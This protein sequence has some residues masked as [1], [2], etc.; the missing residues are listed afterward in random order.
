M[1]NLEL[2]KVFG[3]LIA[4]A[5]LTKEETQEL[6]D[7]CVASNQTDNHKLVGYINEENNIYVELKNSKVVKSIVLMVEDYIRD[8]DSGIYKQ[9]LEKNEFDSIVNLSDAWYNKQT[10]MEYNPL[11]NHNVA[12]DLV[13]VIYPKIN[14]EEDAEYYTVNNSAYQEQKGQIHFVYGQ[15]PNMNGFGRSEFSLEPEQGD[16]LIFPASLLHYTAPVL[17]E[18]F[19]YSISCNFR[20]HNHI[21]RLANK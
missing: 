7:I 4:K 11:H 18:S 20:I 10:A 3:P 8:I 9:T 14:L 1:S 16:I 6:Y 13:C 5:T 21:K 12:A 17:G 15:T 2:Q 19:R